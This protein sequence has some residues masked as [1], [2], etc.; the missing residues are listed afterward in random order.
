MKAMF[1][2]ATG[3]DVGKTYVTAGIIRAMH[4]R[5][6]LASAIKPVMSGYDPHQPEASDAAILLDAMG[7]PVTA[8]D[9]RSDRAL[10]L[11]R[12]PVPRHGRR[13]RR[14]GFIPAGYP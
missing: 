5:G 14:P 8:R 4:E 6:R 7:K 2:T 13:P 9:R 12:S 3:T 1:V 10:A 11:C